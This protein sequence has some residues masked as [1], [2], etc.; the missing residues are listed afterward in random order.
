MEA[1]DLFLYT[2]TS[3]YQFLY[4][5]L[6]SV[7]FGVCVTQEMEPV[8]SNLRQLLRSFPHL[9]QAVHSNISG[10]SSNNVLTLIMADGGYFDQLLKDETG[11]V[12]GRVGPSPDPDMTDLERERAKQIHRLKTILEE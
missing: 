10:P 5:L 3:V 8:A 9:V 4:A 1:G 12:R 7:H 11:Y 2:I 6:K